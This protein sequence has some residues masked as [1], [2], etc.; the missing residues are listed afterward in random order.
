MIDIHCH[1]L[2]GIDDGAKNIEDSLNMARA[3][4]KQGIHTII[5]TPHHQNSKYLN[6]KED[7]LLKVSELNEAIQEENISIT[8]LPGQETRIYGEILEDYNNNEILPLNHS[9]YLFIELPSGHVPRYT[10]QLLYDIQ[11]QGLIPIIVHPERNQEIIERPEILFQFVEKGALTQVTAASISG[12]FGKKIKEFSFQ[13]IDASLTHFL[14]SDA[15]N[16][17]NRNF[18]VVEAFDLVEKRYGVDT[19]DMFLENAEYLV[20]GK[21]VFKDIPTKV[22]RKKI[23][24]IF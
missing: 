11:L 4:V 12:A 9:N 21:S 22:K 10:Q 13:L 24:G 1:I 8:I 14:A 23:L 2:P 19:V 17:S 18:K 15:H 6:P 20:S 16:I 5:A 3:A 7:I